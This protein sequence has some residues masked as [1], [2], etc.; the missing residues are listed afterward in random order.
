MQIIHCNGIK[1]Y[2]DSQ[3]Y[4]LRSESENSVISYELKPHPQLDGEYYIKS[5]ITLNT[6]GE[7]YFTKKFLSPINDNEYEIFRHYRTNRLG[8]TKTIERVQGILPIASYLQ[9]SEIV[10]NINI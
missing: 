1:Y 7:M 9:M 2:C 5:E 6:F 8:E 4:V 3:G 10:S